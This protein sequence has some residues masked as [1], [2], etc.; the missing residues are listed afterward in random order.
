M[1]QGKALDVAGDI[2]AAFANG[3]VPAACANVFLHRSDD[4]PSARWSWR[5][6]LIAALHGHLDARGFRQWQQVGRTVRRGEHAF[7]IL[8]PILVKRSA[9]ED[10][11]PDSNETPGC[12]LV[13]FNAVPVFG[14][15]QTEG[16]PLPGELEHRAFLDSLPLVEVARAWGLHVTT[17][18]AEQ[19]Q[20]LGSYRYSTGTIALGVENLSTWA[21]ELVHMPRPDY[22]DRSL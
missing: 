2:L 17:F 12:R 13:G 18:D 6:R 14:Y 21:H 8:A 15:D 19:S 1:L 7:Y 11:D 16:E 20:T 22:A 10:A 3:T 4:L 5:N 9:G